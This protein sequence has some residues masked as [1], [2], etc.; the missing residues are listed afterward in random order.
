MMKNSSSK[1]TGEKKGR[2]KLRNNITHL[3]EQAQMLKMELM[4]NMIWK[5]FNLVIK[6]WMV[7][8]IGLL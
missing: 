3:Q 1:G 6:V 8:K 2:T 5:W 4:L 7:M